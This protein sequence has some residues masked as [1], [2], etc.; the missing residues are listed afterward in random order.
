MKHFVFLVV[1]FSFGYSFTFVSPNAIRHGLC[2]NECNQI[3]SNKA[4]QEGKDFNREY[5]NKCVNA[6]MKYQDYHNLK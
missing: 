3:A 5:F 1:I 4:R 6:C 2:D